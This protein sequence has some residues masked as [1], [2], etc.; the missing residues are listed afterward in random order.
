MLNELKK[1][2]LKNSMKK[3]FANPLRSKSRQKS[4]F[5]LV[6]NK[7]QKNVTKLMT[8]CNHFK[9]FTP[10]AQFVSSP[11]QN[12]DK[13]CLLTISSHGFSAPR[14]N[15]FHIILENTNSSFMHRDVKQR[16]LNIQK[17]IPTELNYGKQSH[18]HPVWP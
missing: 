5:L 11:W 15:F 10:F 8:T 4:F 2:T 7:L 18:R 13:K 1:K 16:N 17:L 6:S 3:F 12:I 14:K 9:L